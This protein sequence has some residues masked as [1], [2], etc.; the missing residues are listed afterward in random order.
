MVSND[1]A[2][3][4]RIGSTDFSGFLP[5]AIFTKEECESVSAVYKNALIG[6]FSFGKPDNIAIANCL[7]N[8]GFG[9]CKG[10]L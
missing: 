7:F 8:A 5:T 9:K 4:E 3:V 6:K 1:P 10:T 2:S